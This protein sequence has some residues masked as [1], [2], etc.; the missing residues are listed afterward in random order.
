MASVNLTDEKLN[1]FPG[2][3]PFKPGE[4]DLFFGRENE[5]AEI[6]GKLLRNRFVAITGTTGCGKSSLVLCGLIPLIK[7]HASETGEKWNF[8]VMQPGKDPFGDLSSILAG[9]D[10]EGKT[11]L[12]IDQ[13]EEI[14]RYANPE[15]RES[16]G[17]DIK[18]FINLLAAVVNGKYPDIY[19]IV[20]IRSDMISLFEHYRGFSDILNNSSFLLSPMSGNGIREAITGPLEIAGV[21]IDSDLVELLVNEVSE[22]SDQLLELQHAMLH[23]W[24]RWKEMNEPERPVDMTDYG[25]VGTMRYAISRYADEVYFSL[26]QNGRTICE[27]MFRILSGKNPSNKN[28]RYPSSFRE[29]R[30]SIPCNEDE[31]LKVIEGFRNPA[32]SFLNPPYTVSLTDETIIDLSHENLIHLWDRLYNWTEEEASSVQVY[33]RLSETSAL[34]QQ[35]K[36]GLLKEPDLQAAISWRD[37][38]RPTPGWAQK[39]DPAFERAMVYLRTSERE[40]LESEERKARYHKW[41]LHR[42]RIISTV[43]GAIAILAAIATL[44]AVYSKVTSDIRRKEAEQQSMLIESQKKA[45]EQY[46]ATALRRSVESD[47]NAISASRREQMERMLR[48]NAENQIISSRL[49]ADEALK[50][51]RLASQARMKAFMNA[52]SAIKAGNETQRLR[53]ISVARTMSLRSQQSGMTGDLQALLALQAFLFNRKYN[54]SRNDA[55]I[56]MGLYTLAKQRNSDKIKIFEGLSGTVKNILFIPARNA[57]LTSDSEGRV[58]LYDLNNPGSEQNYRLLYTD[59]EIVDVMA[60]SPKA[61][62]LACG[63]GNNSVK[64][65]SLNGSGANYELKGH[66]GKIKSLVFSYDGSF[67]YSAAVD[68]KVLKWNLESGNSVEIETDRTVI[69]SLDVSSDNKYIAGVTE[70]GRGV[71]WNSGNTESKFKIEAAD[72][73]IRCIRFKP[74]EARIAVGYDNGLIEIWDVS[75]G[76][77]ISEFQA[78]SGEIKEIRFSMSDAQMATSG[79]DQT[80]KLWDT[81]DFVSPPVCFND[82]DGIVIGFEFSPEGDVILSGS[83]G[84]KTRIIA[85]PAYADSF[86]AD[87]CSYVTRNF[88]PNEWLAYVGR[89]ITYE[90]T[91]P[92]AEY[93]IKI[94]EIR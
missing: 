1:P 64:M 38:N 76:K 7:R 56:Y 85:R 22:S 30:L 21:E 81:G 78:H 2:L 13:F 83:I 87:G 46:A 43:L 74:D 47:S 54:G 26:D 62:W 67:L 71:V 31:L 36:A 60:V 66:S 52:D 15:I 24:I 55:D 80:L 68:G 94:R 53:M 77:K 72:K 93:R 41:R 75:A 39:Y 11:L 92:E 12:F 51:S 27:K 49:V 16:S 84:S 14:F 86:A 28:I 57:F 25:S 90:K 73:R 48:R 33:L 88:T 4:S 9:Q 61:D 69:T 3:R 89:D 42:I 37:K 63:D 17:S 18:G 6:S 8:I 34:Y 19:L 44:V 58:L 35:G 32:F 40:H 82:N 23:T 79:D 70:Q 5:S 59:R 10:R 50:E 45:A 29:L 20:A 91:C 65:I